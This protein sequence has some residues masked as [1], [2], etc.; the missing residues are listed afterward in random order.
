MPNETISVVVAESG[1]DKTF[2]QTEATFIDPSRAAAVVRD[3][4]I[5]TLRSNLTRECEKFI[6]IVSD[7]KDSKGYN[8]TEIEVGFVI[9]AQAGV[10]FVASGNVGAQASLKMKFARTK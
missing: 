6:D 2:D 3:L 4:P 8:L 5:E 1:G 9:S 7:V 10:S